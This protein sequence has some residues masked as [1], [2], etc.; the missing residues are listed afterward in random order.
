MTP[1]AR[2]I[3]IFIVL[4]AWV[5]ARDGPGLQI[6][7]AG[8]QQ[9]FRTIGKQCP[10]RATVNCAPGTRIDGTYAL[11]ERQRVAL[12]GGVPT[13]RHVALENLSSPD[14]Q[15]NLL[16]HASVFGVRHAS[17]RRSQ[18]SGLWKLHGPRE[19]MI[20]IPCAF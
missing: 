13:S 18:G 2:A 14:R 19:T 6:A 12:E 3:Q 1:G 10:V 7:T 15:S 8:A 9:Q 11:V 20:P 16:G 4:P 5:G 17:Q